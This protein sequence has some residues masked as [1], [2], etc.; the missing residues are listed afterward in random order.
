MEAA[1][2]AKHG[3]TNG[4]A[5][6]AAVLASLLLAAF[7]GTLFCSCYS[8][9]FSIIG[10]YDQS[11]FFRAGMAWVHGM[12]PYVDFVDVKGPLLFAIQAAG[13]LLSPGKLWGIWMIE[14]G[15]LTLLLYFLYRLARVF[16]CTR[17]QAVLAAALSLFVLLQGDLYDCGGRA[18][19]YMGVGFAYLLWQMC[20]FYRGERTLRRVRRFGRAI[21]YCAAVS[22]LIKY[23]GI[24]PAVVA[25]TCGAVLLHS[26]R[27]GLGRA[28]LLQAALGTGIVAFP[29]V[30]YLWAQGNLL[31]AFE[32][33][34][35]LNAE[36]LHNVALPG[37]EMAWLVC[38][39]ILVAP[40]AHVA[41]LG[42]PFMYLLSKRDFGFKVACVVCMVGVGAFACCLSGMGVYYLLFCAPLAIF[43]AVFIIQRF[44]VAK[45]LVCLPLL[46][47]AISILAGR[48]NGM[49]KEKAGMRVRCAQQL[50]PELQAMEDEVSRRPGKRIMFLHSLDEGFGLCSAILPAC[51]EWMTLNGAPEHFLERQREAVRAALPDYV[52]LEVPHPETEA[53]LQGSGYVQCGSPAVTKV[54]NGRT[55]KLYKKSGVPGRP[56][57]SPRISTEIP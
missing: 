4:L 14:T 38:Y 34:F 43:P 17:A 8:P 13:Y 31:A 53:L 28:L 6:K 41:W 51:P 27:S 44:N 48:A 37:L 10:C 54:T 52:I 35:T 24:V 30:L 33:Y 21:G 1:P 49:W 22:V 20:S 50:S 3:G 7:L 18:E 19:L 39:K 16:G 2:T 29:F 9:L 40:A 12:V 55:I 5:E 25:G 42:L 26:A 57:N 23:N 45:S 11:C 56:Q 32:V 36:T 15:A 46:C 47:A